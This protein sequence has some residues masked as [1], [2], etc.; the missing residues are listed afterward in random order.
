LLLQKNMWNLFSAA[1]EKKCKIYLSN[2]ENK[3]VYDNRFILLVYIRQ[4]S[5]MTH[6]SGIRKN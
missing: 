5:H 6:S 2:G 4:S 3:F 1:L